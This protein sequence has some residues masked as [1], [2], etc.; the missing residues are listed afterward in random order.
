M[1]IDFQWHHGEGISHFAAV[2]NL[3][4]LHVF[5][6]SY[7]GPWAGCQMGGSLKLHNGPAF[8]VTVVSN[9]QPLLLVFLQTSKS[10]SF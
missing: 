6:S 7:T 5:S 8:T 3:K 9:W 10:I 4:D 1:F 2:K